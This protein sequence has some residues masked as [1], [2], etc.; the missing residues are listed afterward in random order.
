MVF[1][2]DLIFHTLELPHF[3]PSG[4]NVNELPALEKWLYFLQHAEYLDA[5][6][7]TR[8]A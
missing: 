3:D 2:D 8:V 6:E 5:D 1:S 7:L 4:D